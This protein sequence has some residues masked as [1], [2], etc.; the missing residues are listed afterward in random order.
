MFYSLQTLHTVPTVFDVDFTPPRLENTPP[1][2]LIANRD[3]L[4]TDF[5]ERLHALV[6]CEE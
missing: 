6:W 1:S 5:V 4:F 3:T 2:E